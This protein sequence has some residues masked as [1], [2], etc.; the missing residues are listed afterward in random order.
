MLP[1]VNT[2]P[3]CRLTLFTFNN[4]GQQGLTGNGLS[5]PE[6]AAQVDAESLLFQVAHALGTDM[7]DQIFSDAFDSVQSYLTLGTPPPGG[8]MIA[9]GTLVT[10]NGREIV[11][12]GTTTINISVVP[13]LMVMGA[14][15]TRITELRGLPVDWRHTDNVNYLRDCLVRLPN[16]E[17]E[18]MQ[19]PGILDRAHMDE[20]V[21]H[22]E[23]IVFT[24]A[25]FRTLCQ[26]VTYVAWRQ[27][28]S[29]E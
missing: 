27:S 12:E 16:T 7:T 20:A 21:A 9:V 25:E 2:C 3:T 22:G 23:H 14:Y 24:N 1:R 4:P 17:I 15:F 26:Y 10:V 29:Q 6:A 5:F 11:Y 13:H 28:H 18:V 19:W 8:D